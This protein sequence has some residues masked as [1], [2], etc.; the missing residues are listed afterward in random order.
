MNKD[1][2]NFPLIKKTISKR[3]GDQT[4]YHMKQCIIENKTLMYS[5]EQDG[6]D[7]KK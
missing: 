6:N 1:A 7:I 5:D 4:K 2:K 3:S